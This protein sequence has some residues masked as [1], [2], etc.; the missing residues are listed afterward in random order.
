MSI[1]SF[2]TKKFLKSLFFPA[3]NRGSALPKKLVK[4]LKNPPGYWDLPELPE[5]GSPLSKN[6]LIAA[7]QKESSSSAIVIT[8]SDENNMDM[9]EFLMTPK[10]VQRNFSTANIAIKNC[11]EY[12]DSKTV[13]DHSKNIL[14]GLEATVDDIELKIKTENWL[15]ETLNKSK[16]V[17][18]AI[19]DVLKSSSSSGIKLVDT[20]SESSA[21]VNNS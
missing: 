16:S 1:S 4:L 8:S 13:T 3:H 15:K 10:R 12:I 5:I 6:G 20:L 11:K 21:L 14:L 2:L 7:S 17:S 18:L 9:P 19:E